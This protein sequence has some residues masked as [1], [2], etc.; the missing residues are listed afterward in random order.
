MSLLNPM[1]CRGTIVDDR[2]GLGK[3]FDMK[4]EETNEIRMPTESHIL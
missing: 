3:I 4:N 2:K 1:E